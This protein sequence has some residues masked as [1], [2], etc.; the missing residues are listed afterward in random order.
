[1]AYSP[2]LALCTDFICGPQLHAVHLGDIVLRLRVG[3]PHNLV[4]MEL[5]QG[6]EAASAK[7]D[8]TRMEILATPWSASGCDFIAVLAE[9]QGKLST[10]TVHL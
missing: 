2:E 3:P 5:Q 1:M 8:T 10:R 7:L 9:E 4:L 6:R